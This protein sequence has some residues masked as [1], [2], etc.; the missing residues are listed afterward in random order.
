MHL[1]CWC[2]GFPLTFT[3]AQDNDML[4]CII[5]HHIS[6]NVFPWRHP[7]IHLYPPPILPLG[8]GLGPA[9]NELPKAHDASR[10]M[11][12][13]STKLAYPTNFQAWRQ[14]GE[15]CIT[16]H[17]DMLFHCWVGRKVYTNLAPIKAQSSQGFTNQPIPLM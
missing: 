2:G 13:A 10:Q 4:Y 16:V 3:T 15:F 9:D 17:A 5:F 14:E 6:K 7:V 11:W 12:R 8:I 1:G